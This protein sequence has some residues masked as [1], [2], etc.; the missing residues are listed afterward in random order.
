MKS[1]FFLAVIFFAIT[2]LSFQTAQT[3]FTILGKWAT[4]DSKGLFIEYTFLKDG[5]YKLSTKES[6][7]KTNATA[8]LKYTFDTK[9][10][11]AWIDLEIKNKKD[12][13]MSIKMLG[14]IEVIDKDNFKINLSTFEERPT[15]FSDNKIAV[16]KRVSK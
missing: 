9:H 7:Q 1:R 16:F 14:I 8:E 12:E 4:I 5:H 10:T 11:P 13:K 3:D 15:D 6:Q 2:C